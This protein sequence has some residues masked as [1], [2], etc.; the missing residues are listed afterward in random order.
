MPKAKRQR[1]IVDVKYGVQQP[2]RQRIAK[3]RSNVSPAP[4]KQPAGHGHGSLR[5]Q[6]QIKPWSC[7]SIIDKQAAS[8][9][10]RLI[11][12][13][14][15]H[16][17]GATI[18]SLTLAPHIE[19]KKATYAVT[20][21]TLKHLTLLK[22]LEAAVGLLQQQPR[23]TKGTVYVLL[24]E[25]LLGKGLKAQGPAER[26]VMARI[27][28]LKDAMQRV[29]QQAGAQSAAQYLQA[30]QTAGG[31][32]QVHPAQP[33]QHPRSVRVNTLKGSVDDALKRLKKISPQLVRRP[34]CYHAAMHLPDCSQATAGQQQGM[35]HACFSP[36]TCNAPIHCIIPSAST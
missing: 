14:E 10:D 28:E 31:Q 6:P 16:R 21:E 7:I 29:L 22:E 20:C 4:G 5:Q 12:A 25:A 1:S 27:A 18:K 3:P 2:K 33:V 36:R 11:Q 9:V 23:L 15:T 26:P 19:N 24:Y 17:H 8:A 35:L 13:A 30:Q 34:G 32:Q